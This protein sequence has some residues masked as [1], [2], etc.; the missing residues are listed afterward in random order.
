MRWGGETECG[1][2]N[3]ERAS[4]SSAEMRA[5][6]NGLKDLIDALPTPGTMTDAIAAQIVGMV[7]GVSTLPMVLPNPPTQAQVAAI[8]DK[9]NQ[10][11][12]ALE[13]LP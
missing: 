1:G 7:S 11:I 4:Q 5:Q 6:F 12:T 2:W 3:A 13:S 10:L 9:L 8:I